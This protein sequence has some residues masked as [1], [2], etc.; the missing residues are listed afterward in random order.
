MKNRKLYSIIS[1]FVSCVII[2]GS[3]ASYGGQAFLASNASG[4]LSKISVELSEAM[5]VMAPNDIE[6][7]WISLSDI[8][9]DVVEDALLAEKGLPEKIFENT[10]LL[11]D[12]VALQFE[13]GGGQ[14]V[15]D[16][17]D[18][19]IEEYV[20]ARREIVRQKFTDSNNSFLNKYVNKSRGV[21]YNSNYT[22]TLVVE[23]TKA[24]IEEYAELNEVVSVSL[25]REEEQIPYEDTS[26]TQINADSKSGTKSTRFN[27][28]SGYKGRNIKI[29][30]IE[31]S[32]GIFDSSCPQLKGIYNKRL[33]LANDAGVDGAALDGVAVS[34]HATM[35]TSIIAGQAVTVNGV[36]YEGL[37]PSATIYQT[38]VYGRSDVIRAIQKLVD[39]G[40]SVINYSGGASTANKG[41]YDNYDKEVDLIL[42][43]TGVVLVQAG[44][45]KNMENNENKY[46]CSPG[47]AF[48]SICVGNAATKKSAYTALSAPFDVS[49]T[50]FEETYL[51]NKPD[52]VAPGTSACYVSKDGTVSSGSGTSYAAPVVTGIIAQMMEANS[53]LTTKTGQLKVK[54]MLLTGAQYSKISCADNDGFVGNF[55]R[56]KSGA[57]LVNAILC[58]NTANGKNSRTYS[59]EFNSSKKDATQTLGTLTS[60][61]RVRMVLVFNKSNDKVVSSNADF[62][63]VDISLVNQSTGKTVASSTTLENNVEIIEY[64]VPSGGS[65]TYKFTVNTSK[66]VSTSVNAAVTYLTWRP[67]DLNGDGKTTSNDASMILSYDGGTATL[68][69][70]QLILADVNKDGIVNGIDASLVLQY[71]SGT[72]VELK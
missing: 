29:G 13:N 70:E 32:K 64:T 53:E 33:F 44:T 18:A 27:S 69:P 25:F 50:Y 7:I 62:D 37:A 72:N 68:T 14:S 3:S 6:T 61:Q 12:M 47:L 20:T 31:A 9:D 48:N 30:V 43:K 39:K 23:A 60:G 16:A 5:E 45:N 42:S 66:R 67:G 21:I 41:K 71:D 36:T 24:E 40:C 38:P 15:A 34:S 19:K 58:S 65:G 57:G 46:I 10:D 63:N 8:S 11:K 54:S 51:P 26:L 28:G 49:S 4:S 55:L 2:F 35:V 17:I 52:L 56:E 59:Y 1:F 22:P